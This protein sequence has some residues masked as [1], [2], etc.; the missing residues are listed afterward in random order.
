MEVTAPIDTFEDVDEVI[1]DVMGVEVGVVFMSADE[2]VLGKGACTKAEE[3]VGEGEDLLGLAFSIRDI[4]FGTDGDEKG[5]NACR[6]NGVDGFEARDFNRDHWAGDF[7]DEV[8]KCGVFLRRATNDGEWPDGVFAVVDV[9]DVQDR[10]FMG[11]AVITKVI[12]KRAFGFGFAGVDR[13]GDD[14]VGVGGDDVVVFASV[15]KTASSESTC[16]YEFG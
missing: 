4:A 16:K 5:V 11:K 14:K 13:A 9:F 7:V 2:E 12:T 10:E 6:V 15:A 3:G 1:V 8:A